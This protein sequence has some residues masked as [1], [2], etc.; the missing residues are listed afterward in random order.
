MVL[1]QIYL[2]KRHERII[3]RLKKLY[4]IRNKGDAVK[5]GLELAER[6]IKNNR[7]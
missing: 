5:K 3:V 7:R 2:E 6:Y 4:K 1:A